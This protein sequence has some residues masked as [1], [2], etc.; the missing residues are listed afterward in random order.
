MPLMATG[1]DSSQMFSGKGLQDYGCK[2][3][4]IIWTSI[5]SSCYMQLV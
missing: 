4:K 3:C 1:T 2:S 5:P